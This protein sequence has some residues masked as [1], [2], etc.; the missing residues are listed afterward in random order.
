MSASQALSA[1]A[2]LKERFAQINNLR[3]AGDILNKDAETVMAPGSGP[4]RTQQIMALATARNSLISAPEV[5]H[6]L[7]D[8]ERNE[9]TMSVEDC[10]N[11]ALMRR[12]WI[13]EASLPQDL[14][15]E[16]A[17]LESEGQSLHTELRKTGR[18][19]KIKD[20]YAHSFEVMRAVG[21]IKQDKLGS[22]STYEALLDTFSAG[23][24]EAMVSREFDALEKAL[25]PLIREATQRQAMAPAPIPL[26]GQFP[27]AQQEELCHRLAERLGFDFNRGVLSVIHGHPSCNG[28]PD[29][30]RITTG[31]DETNFLK[32]V[33]SA[34]HEGGHGLF[35]Q[36]MPKEWRYQPAGDCFAMNI[37][38]TQSRII[39]VQ[40]CHTPEFFQYL[41]KEAREIFNRPDDP[42]LSAENLERLTNRVT[43]S[44]IRI[45]ADELTYPAHVIVRHKLEKAMIEGTIGIDDLPKAWN[46]NMKAILG[47]TPPDPSQG[48]M[49]D[50]HWPAGYVGYFP[51]YTLGD[52]GASQF[53]A[54]ACKAKPEIRGEIAKGNFTP[55]REWLYD[56]V[57][58]KGSLLTTDELFVG[59]TGETLNAKYYLEHLSRRYLGHPWQNA[60]DS[61][62]SP[63]P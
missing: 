53:F 8:A 6:W 34:V 27:H 7:N 61:V 29:D 19:E 48:C 50:V 46:D 4:D 15:T 24:S 18:W 41:E 2:K 40:A 17:R 57:H 51:A 35:Q 9:A 1:Y 30:T 62:A 39:E 37:H 58:S 59:A 22:A 42:A 31:C 45:Y 32:A 33:Y 44:L 54:A 26:E 38:E 11:L 20:W 28:S 16:I 12:Q 36:N 63:H 3:Y 23:V 14:A 56:N 60:Q 47:V 43:P 49:Q 10:R 25:P 13:H 21:K 52:M 5:E 55:L